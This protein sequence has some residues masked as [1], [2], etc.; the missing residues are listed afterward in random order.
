MKKTKYKPVFLGSLK[1]RVGF[2]NIVK[3]YNSPGINDTESS[4]QIN[5]PPDNNFSVKDDFFLTKSVIF[6]N[7]YFVSPSAPAFPS[8]AFDNMVSRGGFNYFELGTPKRKGFDSILLGISNKCRLN[9]K[10]CYEA[11]NLK[12][13]HKSIPT[14][15]WKRTIAEIQEIGASIIILTG[16]EPLLEF[17]KLIELLETGNKDLS[18]FHVHTSGDGLTDS[19]VKRLKSA[20]MKAAAVGLDDFDEERYER[21]RGKKGLFKTALKA[22]D[23]FNRNGIF[24]FANTCV[25]KEFLNSGDIYKFYDLM[26]EHNVCM[27]DLL[28]PMPWG[29]FINE[30]KENAFTIEDKAKLEEFVTAVSKDKKYLNHPM[31]YYLSLIEKP[32]NMGCTMGGLSHMYIDSA[33]NVNPCMFLPVSFGNI[34][35]ESFTGIY[36]RMREAI[37]RPVKKE[38]PS[39]QLKKM[40]KADSKLGI[41][42]LKYENIKEEFDEAIS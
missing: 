13:N 33:G 31:V 42:P 32:C 10:H 14:E 1:T 24:T 11:H 3:K 30:T 15:T 23:L 4:E 21:L 28:E 8:K 36:N 22:L 26:K 18:D 16:G 19:M 9:C 12:S 25:T 2:Y 39:I 35:E 40:L 5:Y 38:C 20:G 34:N 6:N 27:I 17:D 7:Q 37:K 41:I 29:G